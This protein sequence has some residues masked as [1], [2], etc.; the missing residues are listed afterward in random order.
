M[1]L[2]FPVD[3]YF[4]KGKPVKKGGKL[5]W[6]INPD[7]P[8]GQN[9]GLDTVSWTPGGEHDSSITYKMFDFDSF[10]LLLLLHS[11]SLQF[12]NISN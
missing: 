3:R 5:R 1:K 7:E 12:T 8:S 2:W 6:K 11:T 4:I 10:C 9:R